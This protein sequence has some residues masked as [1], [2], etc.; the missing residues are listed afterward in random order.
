MT[1]VRELQTK[2][3]QL[4][5][6][7]LQNVDAETANRHRITFAEKLLRIANRSMNLFVACLMT[8]LFLYGGYSLWDNWRIYHSALPDQDLMKLKPVKG[9]DT[10]PSLQDLQK[11]NADVCA[12]L[13]VDDTGIDYPVVRGKDD[14]E[15]INKDVYGEFSL[16]GSI[17]LSCMNKK[18]FSDNYN[19]VYGHHMANGGMFGDVVSFTEKSYFDKHKTG[20]LYLPDKTMHIDLFACMKT[21]AS[22]SKVYNPQN[23]SKTS[24]SFKSFLDYVRE[25][26]ICYRDSGRQDTGQIIGLSTCSEAVT[27]GRVILFGRLSEVTKSNQK[28]KKAE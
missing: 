23:I 1:E 5:K 21:S 19:L 15:Y 25:A 26:A 2:M 18:D 20:E 7:N 13:T 28:Q 8:V 12:W 10:N 9:E 14:M 16:S 27:N 17:F 11:I 22:D 3:K 24:E 4:N 6:E